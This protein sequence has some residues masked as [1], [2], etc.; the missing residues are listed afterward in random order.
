M[1]RASWDERDRRENRDGSGDFSRGKII[2]Q[3]NTIAE[4]I[5]TP[6]RCRSSGAHGV[7]RPTRPFL[8]SCFPYSLLLLVLLV[9]SCKQEQRSLVNQPPSGDTQWARYEVNVAPSRDFAQVKTWWDHNAWSMSEGKQLYEA[10]NCVGCHA[11]GGGGMGPA[12]MD[13]KW[14]YGSEPYQIYASIRQGRPNGMPS[15]RGKVPDNQIWEIVAYVR[16][17]SGLADQWYANARDDHLKAAPP[18]NSVSEETPHQTSEPK[19]R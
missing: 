10:Y 9:P 19:P 18:P 8:F 2:N 4:T 1:N 7:T 13:N 3:K 6:L 5:G 17:M 14:I 12:L 16:S 11:H 15:F